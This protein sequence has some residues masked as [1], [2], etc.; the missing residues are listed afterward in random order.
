MRREVGGALPDCASLQLSRQR[1]AGAVW[2]PWSGW[3]L[4][5]WSPAPMGAGGGAAGMVARGPGHRALVVEGPSLG[6][7]WYLLVFAI[8]VS[9]PPRASRMILPS[10]HHG[11]PLITL[12]L[13]F[14][15]EARTVLIE[16]LHALGVIL[17]YAKE[18]VPD[19]P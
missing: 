7:I 1:R 5:D 16:P 17:R 11:C 18:I 19:V 9:F 3:W 8:H 2:A 10:S 15:E 14:P 4:S 13:L 12:A 6:H